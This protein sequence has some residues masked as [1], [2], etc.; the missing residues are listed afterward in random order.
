MRTRGL[1]DGRVSA[2]WSKTEEH[3]MPGREGKKKTHSLI[4]Q[5]E[6]GP[7]GSD[8]SNKSAGTI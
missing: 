5:K 4:G 7:Q 3:S 2:L 8:E 6:L 1:D